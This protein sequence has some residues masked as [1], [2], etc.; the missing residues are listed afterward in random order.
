MAPLSATHSFWRQ[1]SWGQEV[2]DFLKVKWFSRSFCN[3]LYHRLINFVIPV[4]LAFPFYIKWL[5]P[6]WSTFPCPFSTHHD[7]YLVYLQ[8]LKGKYFQTEVIMRKIAK[9]PMPCKVKDVAKCPPLFCAKSLLEKN[10]GVNQVHLLHGHWI[11]VL[12]CHWT[13]QFLAPLVVS[14]A[15]LLYTSW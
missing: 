7:M 15:L 12:P 8:L 14:C 6:R 13:A 2:S 3:Q 10:A 5:I 9:A 4:P 11:W 1:G